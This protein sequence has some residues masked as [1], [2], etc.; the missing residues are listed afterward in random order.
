MVGV[1]WSRVQDA[2]VEQRCVGESMFVVYLVLLSE[3]KYYVLIVVVGFE[4]FLVFVMLAEEL[5]KCC[6]RAGAVE[7][8]VGD[9]IFVEL[10][11]GMLVVVLV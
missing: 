1:G 11:V 4:C 10:Y 2:A 3:G 9:E 5:G 7:G 8:S 6:V